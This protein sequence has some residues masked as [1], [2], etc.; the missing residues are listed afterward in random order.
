[1]LLVYPDDVFARAG[2]SIGKRHSWWVLAI[3]G[4]FLAV[5]AAI[6]TYHLN[7]KK[8][9]CRGLLRTIE[10]SD[11]LWS[12]DLMKYRIEQTFFK[13][14]EAWME[15]DQSICRDFVSDRLYQRHEAQTDRLK[16]LGH[17]NIMNGVSLEKATIVEIADYKN[18]DKDVFLAN[19]EGSMV[20]YVIDEKTE[21]LIEGEKERAH[22]RE[23]WKFRRIE[24]DWKL[25]EIDS[26]VS[27]G[28]ISSLSSFSEEYDQPPT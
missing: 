16:A 2:G 4:P 15:R 5:Y 8:K 19:I 3:F 20:D 12:P 13:V 28:D 1:M 22:F 9:E 18:D 26:N 7:K 23:L 6:I 14:Q 24:N 27:I 11:E 17:K 21:V 10:N 25:D